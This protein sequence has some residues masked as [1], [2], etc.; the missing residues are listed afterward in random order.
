M[1]GQASDVSFDCYDWPLPPVPCRELADYD[2]DVK[3]ILREYCVGCHN[4]QDLEGELS[5]ETFRQLMKGGSEGP[6]IVVGQTQ[7][8]L[9]IR[10]LTGQATPRMPPK[11]EPKPSPEQIS[12][13]ATWIDEGARGPAP[14]EDDSM[15]ETLTV[16]L[17][18]AK[19]GLPQAITAAEYSPD[20]T[21]LAVG[22]YQ[23]LEVIEVG[24]QQVGA[25]IAGLPGKIMAVH[26]SPDGDQLV[27]ASGVAGLSGQA[28]LWDA[29]NGE[30]LATFSGE[31]QDLLYDAEFSPDGRLLASAG[32]DRTIILWRLDTAE[33]IRTISATTAPCSI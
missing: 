17:I 29:T 27:A 13:L 15:L 30:Q 7:E 16:P 1:G 14:E 9:F 23:R 28:I 24:T 11:K 12:V 5:V 31:H 2:R 25:T 4:D 22:R 26:F 21:R 32:Y 18:A 20:G 10:V 8:S 6:A 3:P 33:P 19:A